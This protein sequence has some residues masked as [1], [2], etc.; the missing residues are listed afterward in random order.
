MKL[1]KCGG[2]L[3][4]AVCLGSSLLFGTTNVSAADLDTPQWRLDVV[5]NSTEMRNFRADAA[6]HMSGSGQMSVAGLEAL[7][8]KLAAVKPVDEPL[9]IVDLRQESHGFLNGEALSWHAKYNAANIGKDAKAVEQDEQAR[10][11]ATYAKEVRGV[12]M[13]KTD[14]AS[15]M[16]PFDA[17]VVQAVTEQQVAHVDG[18]GYVRI[19]A[20]DMQAPEPQAVDAFVDFYKSLPK[21]PGWLHFHCHAGEGRT[22]TFMAMYEML[23]HPERSVDEVLQHQQE[24]GGIDLRQKGNR[25]AMLKNFHQYIRENQRSVYVKSWSDWLKENKQLKKVVL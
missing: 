14:T 10:L 15:G 13:G 17:V 24:I 16:L 22:T 5:Q 11:A 19:A 7:P 6:D 18:F 1:K 4:L 3:L 9:W 20:T 25:Y 21:N 23:Q 2:K 8:D 12:P